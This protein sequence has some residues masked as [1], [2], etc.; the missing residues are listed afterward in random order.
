MLTV[1]AI[2]GLLMIGGIMGMLVTALCVVSKRS[3]RHE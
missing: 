2:I 3:D 1:F